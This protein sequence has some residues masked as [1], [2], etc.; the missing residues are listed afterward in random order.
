MQ[1]FCGTAASVYC[2]LTA[3]EAETGLAAADLAVWLWLKERRHVGA[4][5]VVKTAVLCQS[6]GSSLRLEIHKKAR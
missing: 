6:V 2:W 4:G 1:W 5:Q 3:G